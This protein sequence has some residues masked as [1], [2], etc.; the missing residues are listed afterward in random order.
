MASKADKNGLALLSTASGHLIYIQGTRKL[1]PAIDELLD[2][3]INLICLAI[4]HW[5]G[6]YTEKELKI[7]EAKILEWGDYIDQFVDE[8]DKLVVLFSV[9]T[10]CMADLFSLTKDKSKLDLIQPIF[11][12]LSKLENK[13]DPNG[14]KY[15]D[16]GVARKLMK[17]LYESFGLP[18][19]LL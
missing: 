15:D 3:V 11:P 5:P 18:N 9:S 12:A 2:D 6:Q 10:H 14:N 8:A 4:K 13:F 7:I 19:D 16:Y 17:K 1:G